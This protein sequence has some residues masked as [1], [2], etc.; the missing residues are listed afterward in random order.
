MG[1]PAAVVAFDAVDA[2]FGSG[3][4]SGHA[5]EASAAL[6]HASGSAGSSFAWD[7]YLGDAKLVEV[8]FDSGFAIPAIGGHGSRGST[9]EFVDP[10]DGG[11]KLGSV[12]RVAD[13]E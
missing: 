13:F 9:G 3:A 11:D 7:A 1:S 8:G 2:S 12:G 10:F 4:P 5:L 6:N